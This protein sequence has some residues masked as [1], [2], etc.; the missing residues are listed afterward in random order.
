MRWF[1]MGLMRS[2]EES[3]AAARYFA[4]SGLRRRDL[5]ARSRWRGVGCQRLVRSVTLRVLQRV[6]AQRFDF[7]E[8]T[9]RLHQGCS[10]DCLFANALGGICAGPWRVLRRLLRGSCR[11]LSAMSRHGLDLGRTGSTRDYRSI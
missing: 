6:L 9:R 3:L 5:L 10:G 2:V 1:A 4:H 7:P 8:K 11:A